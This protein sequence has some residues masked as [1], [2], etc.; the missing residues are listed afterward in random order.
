MEGKGGS[1]GKK[2]RIGGKMFYLSLTTGSDLEL[3]ASERAIKR[4]LASFALLGKWERI[5]GKLWNFQF[6]W[7][8]FLFI[9]CWDWDLLQ[10]INTFKLFSLFIQ[11]TRTPVFDLC[12]CPLLYCYITSL[13]LPL[14][15]FWEEDTI[16]YLTCF[17]HFLDFFFFN[18]DYWLK[19]FYT[20]HK[21]F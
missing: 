7:N 6:Q 4:A 12:Q 11:T 13:P 2:M 5:P 19:I 16:P 8:L 1:E 14:F 3:G 18:I 17:F 21:F 9:H 10:I 15:L 20:F